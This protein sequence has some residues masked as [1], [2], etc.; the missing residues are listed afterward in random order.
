M[1]NVA[2]FYAITI[3]LRSIGASIPIG[4]FV[5]SVITLILNLVDAFGELKIKLSD[6]WIGNFGMELYSVDVKSDRLWEIL[7]T[8]LIYIVLLIGGASLLQRKQEA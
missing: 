2:M 8:S 4:I 3:L 7:I 1:A 5:P 6:Y